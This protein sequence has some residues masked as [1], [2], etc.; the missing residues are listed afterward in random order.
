MAFRAGAE[1]NVVA[2]N[3][4]RDQLMYGTIYRLRPRAGREADVVALVE[5]WATK[6]GPQV[7]GTRAVYLLQSERRS[8]DLLGV[9]VFES[10]EAFRANAASP[11]QDAWYRQIRDLLEEDPEWE[12]G[13]YLVAVSLPNG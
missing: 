6:R 11:E 7:Q 3:T 1:R 5:E 2:V 4:G 13:A 9:A 8:G 12:D 10:E